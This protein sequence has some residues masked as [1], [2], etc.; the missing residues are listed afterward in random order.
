M[1]RLASLTLLILLICLL[2]AWCIAELATRAG[3]GL[4]NVSMQPAIGD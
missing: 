2:L 3:R 1:T 4:E